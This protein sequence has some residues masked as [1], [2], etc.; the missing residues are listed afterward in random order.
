MH[1]EKKREKKWGLQLP[2]SHLQ[3]VKGITSRKNQALPSVMLVIKKKE[4]D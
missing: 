3:G 1:K 2:A 4:R